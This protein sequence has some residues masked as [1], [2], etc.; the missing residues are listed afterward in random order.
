MKRVKKASRSFEKGITPEYVAQLIEAYN[1]YFYHYEETPLLVV[2]TNEIDFVNQP[3][4]F[5]DLVAQIR[6]ARKGMQ[7]YVPAAHG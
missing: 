7:Y 5:D 2:D 4:D 3:A 6:R 1:Y